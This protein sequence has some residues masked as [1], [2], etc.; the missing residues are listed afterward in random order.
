MLASQQE[1]SIPST[2]FCVIR[3]K[4]MHKLAILSSLLYDI[5]G[6]L[7]TMVDKN[8]RTYHDVYVDVGCNSQNVEL[9]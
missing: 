6:F 1:K 2:F 5:M 7:L 8:Q 3:K 9:M 4:D